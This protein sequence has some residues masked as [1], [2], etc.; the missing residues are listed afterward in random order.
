[1]RKTIALV[2]S[3]AGLLLGFGGDAHAQTCASCVTLPWTSASCA[4]SGPC[5]QIANTASSSG[6]AI[7]GTTATANS[8]GLVGETFGGGATGTGLAG[9]NMATSGFGVEGQATN[10]SGTTSYGVGGL[11]SYTG[12]VT[13]A[14]TGYG[15]GVYGASGVPT[16]AGVYGTSTGADSAGVYGYDAEAS[17]YGVYGNVTGTGASWGIAGVGTAGTGGG[18]I[19]VTYVANMYGVEGVAPN[20]SS[21]FGVWASGALYGVYGTSATGRGV[22]GSTSTGYGVFVSGGSAAPAV[23]AN[24]TGTGTSAAV[25]ASNTGGTGTYAG[26]FNGNIFVAGTPYCRGCTLFTKP[27]DERLK[28]NIEPMSGALDVLARLRP[29]TFEWK[30][31]ATRGGRYGAQRGFI[32]QEVEKVEPDWVGVDAQGYKTL[33]LS[34]LPALTV[35]SI[36][37]LK[38]KNEALRERVRLLREGRGSWLSRLREAGNGFGLLAVAGVVFSTRRR[39]AAASRDRISPSP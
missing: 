29:V 37:E 9:E 5:I 28:K 32:A 21:A 38:T 34:G 23:S 13:V 14:G 25:Y 3:T 22:Q 36:K 18:V 2:A 12:S 19:G 27:S 6:T 16:G 31:P 24:S 4:A 1:M 33:N 8:A 17:S 20:T 7:N 35:E 10:T 39:R 26:M 15:S 30:D 11:N